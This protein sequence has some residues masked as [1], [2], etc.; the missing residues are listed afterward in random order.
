MEDRKGLCAALD[1]S[2]DE[3]AV[4]VVSQ[5]GTILA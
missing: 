4:C 2:P 3:T 1:V 5:D